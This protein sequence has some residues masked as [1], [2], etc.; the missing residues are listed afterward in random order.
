[1]SLRDLISTDAIYVD[2]NQSYAAD[3]KGLK[4]FEVRKLEWPG[5]D[6]R[7]TSCDLAW[8]YTDMVVG[9]EEKKPADLSSSIGSRR[10]QRQ[11]RQLMEACD[12]VVLALHTKRDYLLGFGE[13][14]DFQDN[15]KRLTA[16]YQMLR[17][18]EWSNVGHTVF[19]PSLGHR[20]YLPKLRTAIGKREGLS[21][22]AGTDR[23][24]EDGR[25]PFTTAMRRLFN[26]MG[27]A[28]AAKLEAA[29]GGDFIKAVTSNP[30]QWRKVGIH[31]GIVKQLEALQ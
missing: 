17:L 9:V 10:L 11:L 31:K 21:I 28:L 13:A 27:P 1:M 14:F 3:L 12:I 18:A 2:A 23:V 16:D 6:G 24:R 25:T 15:G 5:T 4:G 20:T 22:L 19:I 26:G 8:R 29:Y 30:A 7:R